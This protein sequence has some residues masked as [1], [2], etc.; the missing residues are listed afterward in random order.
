MTRRQS[1]PDATGSSVDERNG[2]VAGSSGDGGIVG[3]TIGISMVSIWVMGGIKEGVVLGIVVGI[4][5]NKITRP[6]D[7]PTLS[8]DKSDETEITEI[9]MTCTSKSLYK[10]PLYQ[11]CMMR[12]RMIKCVDER[13]NE[14][15][16]E[17]IDEW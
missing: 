8:L 15:V 4:I 10:Y 6:V 11:P 17:C 9:D 12:K 16:N 3:E 13:M 5:P 7:V 2:E 1:A 14:W